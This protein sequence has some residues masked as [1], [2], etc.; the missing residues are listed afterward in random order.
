MI[1]ADDESAFYWTGL[2]EHR[3]LLQQCGH[4]HRRRFPPMPSCPWCGATLADIV[5]STGSGQVYSWVT[6]HRAFDERWA[7]E[8]P[9]TIAAVELRERC[10]MFA[11]VEVDEHGIH[12]GLAVEPRFV[13]HVDWTELR[14]VASGGAQ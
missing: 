5:E 3:V 13:D 1:S 8:L 9:Y 14:F 6:V 10:R 2:T 12:A 7:G 4:C 11:R